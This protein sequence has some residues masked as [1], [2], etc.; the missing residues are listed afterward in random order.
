MI[1]RYCF[2]NV[3]ANETFI[4]MNFVS[5]F[6]FIKYSLTVTVC[7]SPLGGADDQFNYRFSFESIQPKK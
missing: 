2:V 1:E 7:F 3:M 6:V 4:L 5:F